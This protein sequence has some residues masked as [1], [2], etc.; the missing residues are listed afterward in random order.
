MPHGAK[1]LA[2]SGLRTSADAVQRLAPY[3]TPPYFSA[4]SFA[5]LLS[6]AEELPAA[7]SLSNMFERQMGAPTS[8]V[9]FFH[10]LTRPMGG[11][12]F[13]GR[14][15]VLAGL[16]EGIPAA[17]YDHEAW[18][19]IRDFARAWMDDS[20]PLSEV[21]SVWLEYDVRG[22]SSGVPTP[23]IFFTVEPHVSPAPA[24]EILQHRPLAS[25]RLATFRRC[26]EAVPPTVR[27]KTAG[28][29]YSRPTEA[30]RLIFIIRHDDAFR[31]LERVGW[32]GSVGELA[33][34]VEKFLGFH[35]E[36]ALHVD[37]HPEGVEPQVG[38]EIYAD[39]DALYDGTGGDFGPLLDAAVEQSLCL[40]EIRDALNA[41]PGADTFP[42]P[43]GEALRAERKF[44]HVKV[45]SQPGLGLR[46][47]AY[48][49]AEF[50]VI[51]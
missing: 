14:R 44:H 10:W 27:Y 2:T 31:Y 47:K 51:K 5:N 38:M 33:R 41:W 20:S 50:E 18:R 17:F 26:W 11:E 16:S 4:E 12:H 19:R 24:L 48:T 15:D 37:A 42:L 43:G 21:L 28:I 36:V 39:E 9:D 46:A 30:I 34:R 45:V 7:L 6:T 49:T 23:L 3:C 32:P 22:S 25:P 35:G 40:P 1:S 13:N 29:L 8:P